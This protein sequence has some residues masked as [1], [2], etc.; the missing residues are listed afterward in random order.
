MEVS[1]FRRF[2]AAERAVWP[3]G[4]AGT[5]AAPSGWILAPELTLTRHQSDQPSDPTYEEQRLPV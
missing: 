4:C 1:D 5:A 3:V 2:G